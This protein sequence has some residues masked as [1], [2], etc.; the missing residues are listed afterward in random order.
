[1]SSPSPYADLLSRIPVEEHEIELFGSRTRY[2][3]YG[4]ADAPT[5]IIASHGYRGEHHGLEPVVAHTTG[6]RWISPDLPGFGESSPMTELPHSIAGYGEWF[7]AFVRATGLE[8][9]AV[10]LGH[11][12][13][14][15]VTSQAVSAGLNAPALILINP[16]AIS[17]LEAPHK[18]GTFVTVNWYRINNALPRPIAERLLRSRLATVFVTVSLAKSRDR[19]LRRW[20]HDQHNTYFNRFH[21]RDFVIESFKAS[22]ENNVGEYVH[23]ISIPVLLLAAELD[24]IT[25]ISSIHEMAERMT[26]ARVTVLDGVGHLIHYESPAPAAAAITAFLDELDLSHAENQGGS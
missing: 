25:P 9:S 10:I 5:T 16:I 1:M 7:S 19:A 4:A 21:D 2:W 24:D 26:D 20:I 23:D 15:I 14:S 13:G 8:G 17:G 11:S 18:V 6:I 3:V 22:I 12:F